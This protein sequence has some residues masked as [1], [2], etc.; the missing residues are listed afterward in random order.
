MI[1]LAACLLAATFSRTMD[2]ISTMDPVMAQSAYD[3]RAAKLVYESV[4]EIDYAARPYRLIPGACELPEVSEDGLVYRFRMRSPLLTAQ[5]VVRTLDRARAPATAAPGG[6]ML[7]RISSLRALDDRTVEIRLSS[8]QHVF[9]WM[10]TYSCIT[11]A[12]G[13]GTGPYRLVDWRRNHAMVFERRQKGKATG[14]DTVRYLVVDDAST[15]WLMF[16]KGEIDLLG[17]VSR[18]NWDSVFGLDGRLDPALVRQGVRVCETPTLD[19]MYV[20]INMC[21]PVLG[22]NRKLRQAL[23]AAFDFPAW[24]RFYNGRIEPSDGPI[25]HGVDGRLE[26][27]FAYAYDPDLARRLL[28]E[29]GYPNGIDPK[30]GRRLV[31]T[32]TVGRASQDGREASELMASFY[33]RVGIR[34]ET[35]FMTWDAFLKAMNERRCQLYRIGWVGDYPDAENFLQLFHSRNVSPGSNHSNYANPAFD[36]AYDAAMA[37]S[38]AAERNVHWRECQEI[39][40]EDC[41]WI[42]THYPKSYSLVRRRV[43]NYIP[44]AFSYGNEKHYEV[45][46]P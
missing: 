2:R 43:G 25:P 35:S 28:R 1:S 17:E 3:Y 20:G 10:L 45:N 13:S 14:F 6:F 23:N 15:Q 30:T 29:A 38:T 36:R 19:S 41:P 33:E 12:D 26:T 5:D 32:L 34:L 7:R 8:R 22:P 16:L 46:E 11:R 21:D 31:L 24:R 18:D 40:R 42:F 37:A 9:P 44:G 39:V 27:P 4:L